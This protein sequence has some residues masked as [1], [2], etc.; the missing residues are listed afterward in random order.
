MMWP[1]LGALAEAVWSA[2]AGRDWD[3][4]LS[5]LGK[6]RRGLESLGLRLADTTWRPVISR[7]GPAG[8]KIVAGGDGERPSRRARSATPAT[9]ANRGPAPSVTA[10]RS[11]AV[12]A[13]C[14]RA[15]LFQGRERLGPAV[16]FLLA[17]HLAVFAPVKLSASGK[18]R[19]EAGGKAS[20]STASAGRCSTRTAPGWGWRV[21]TW[22]R[23]STWAAAA[24]S[25][26]WRPAS[27]TIPPPGYSRR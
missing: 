14:I 6:L 2:P 1:R 3:S 15:A 7:H 8:D 19:P 11:P 17:E 16:G 23:S 26:G 21:A 24:R 20:L 27:S 10:A 4:F 5:R 12:P 25:A 13:A 18:L 9:T 22:R